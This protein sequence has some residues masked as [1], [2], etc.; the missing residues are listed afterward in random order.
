MKKGILGEVSVMKE[1]TRKGYEIYFPVTDSS[2]YDLIAEKDRKV[3]RVECK[4][5][6]KPNQK[7]TYEVQIKKVRSNK[8]VIRSFPLIIPW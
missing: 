1:L 5:C 4:S 2:S 8:N 3:Y 7:G 6:K